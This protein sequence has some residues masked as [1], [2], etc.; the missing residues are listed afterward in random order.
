MSPA[1][2][3]NIA[4]WTVIT[5]SVYTN[6][7][8]GVGNT[9][10]PSVILISSIFWLWS[11]NACK[12]IYPHS[13]WDTFSDSLMGTNDKV[14]FLPYT[15]RPIDHWRYVI[16]DV[17]TSWPIIVFC[18]RSPTSRFRFSVFCSISTFRRQSSIPIS[19]ALISFVKISYLNNFS[20]AVALFDF[21][22]GIDPGY[23]HQKRMLQMRKRAAERSQ[24]WEDSL[25][26]EAIHQGSIQL[27]VKW[28]EEFEVVEQKLGFDDSISWFSLLFHF[29]W[30]LRVEKWLR[31][32][33]V[34]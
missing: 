11:L 12:T 13:R 21:F 5:A 16:F 24:K 14:V 6:G 17:T 30:P 25:I 20:L 2:W 4:S 26:N 9:A 27:I 19:S 8:T 31:T 10:T 28:Y 29:D 3:G 34:S 1:R 18:N 7:N 33:A 15:N 32:V 23:C 22:P